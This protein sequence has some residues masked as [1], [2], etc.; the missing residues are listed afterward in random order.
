MLCSSGPR[1]QGARRTDQN[2]A[3]GKRPRKNTLS[4]FLRHSSPLLSSPLLSSP[5]ALCPSAQAAEKPSHP[6]CAGIRMFLGDRQISGLAPVQ[7]DRGLVM[8]IHMMKWDSVKIIHTET[9]GRANV[10]LFCAHVVFQKKKIHSEIQ[11]N[12][13]SKKPWKK[14]HLYLFYCIRLLCLFMCFNILFGFFN[15]LKN[16]HIFVVLNVSSHLLGKYWKSE[17]SWAAK[18]L[19]RHHNIYLLTLITQIIRN[20][21]TVKLGNKANPCCPQ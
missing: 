3:A 10:Q 1:E 11:Q 18:L 5:P 13:C 2:L 4:L 20:Q 16:K 21:C 15:F 17:S 19:K 14:Q 7:R 9:K 12:K 8:Q 6:S